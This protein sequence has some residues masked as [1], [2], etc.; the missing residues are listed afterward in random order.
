MSQ[1]SFIAGLVWILI[2]GWACQSHAQ[3]E[4]STTAN[5]YLVAYKPM[6]LPAHDL[7]EFAGARPGGSAYAFEWISVDRTHVVQIGSNSGGNLLVLSGDSVGVS[8]LESL[9]RQADI[10]PRQIEIEVQIVEISKNKSRDV[11]VDWDDIFRR[12]AIAGSAQWYSEKTSNQYNE[13][14]SNRRYSQISGSTNIVGALKMLDQSGAGTVRTAPRVLTMNDRLATILDGKRVTYVTRYS[15]YSNLYETDSMDAGLTL[16]V[17]PSVTESGYITMHVTAEL[18]SL[19]S[20]HI[21]DSPVKTGQIIENTVIVKDGQS[22]LLG[23]RTETIESRQIKRFPL[24]GWV[25]P[26]LFSREVTSR[27]QIESFVVLTPHSV[28]IDAPLDQKSKDAIEGR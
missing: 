10:A 1:K 4:P 24:L 15:A 8:L 14:K 21:S 23:G 7:L 17:L 11:G 16:R 20:L 12:I 19:D 5:S 25:L 22:V 2:L 6:Y 28:A 27:D 9:F 26:F 13:A 3:Q 18:T